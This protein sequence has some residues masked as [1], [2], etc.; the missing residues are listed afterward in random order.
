MYYNL[1]IHCHLHQLPIKMERKR[2]QSSFPTFN[3]IVWHYLVLMTLLS[4]K[5]MVYAC[6]RLMQ[7]LQHPLRE[8]GLKKRK[9]EA[10]S[11]L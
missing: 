2:F 10:L 6:F 11:V 1:L 7:K 9:N 8:K 3:S 4:A 5:D